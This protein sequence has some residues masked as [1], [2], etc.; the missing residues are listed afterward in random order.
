MKTLHYKLAWVVIVVFI[1][2]ISCSKKFLEEAP[3][4][5]TIE[6]VQW[7]SPADSAALLR[8]QRS[9]TAKKILV[10]LLARYPERR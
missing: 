6:I 4:Q 2:G 7:G 1:S 9:S 5:V 8:S 10:E 3:R